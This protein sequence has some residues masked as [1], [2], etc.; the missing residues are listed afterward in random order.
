MDEID[1]ATREAGRID[2]ASGYR[3]VTIDGD[4]YFTHDVVWAP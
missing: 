3:V 4:E 2:G 1:E